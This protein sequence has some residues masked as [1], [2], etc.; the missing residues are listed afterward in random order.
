ME[1]IARN[2]LNSYNGYKQVQSISGTVE[3]SYSKLIMV[4]KIMGNK[5]ASIHMDLSHYAK[6]F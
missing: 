2:E 3:Y 5:Y 1:G 6:T 4:V